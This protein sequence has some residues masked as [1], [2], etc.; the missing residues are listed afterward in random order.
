L[1]QQKYK[2]L[3]N[4]HLI[5]NDIVVARRGEIGRC[6]LVRKEEQLFC[7]TGSMFIRIKANYSPV[8][9]QFQI[10]NTSIKDF[11]ES[12]AKGVTMKN[13]NSTTIGN[14]YVLNPPLLEQNRFE[15]IISRVESEKNGYQK[16]LVDLENLYTSLSQR[17]FNGKIFWP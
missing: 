15:S 5:I 6:A 1:T 12:K 8:F 2:D 11:L 7:G 9:L 4:Y 17:A 16:S 3:E 13:L 14:L 10:Y